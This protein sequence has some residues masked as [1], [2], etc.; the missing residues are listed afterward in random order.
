MPS[1]MYEIRTKGARGAMS[2]FAGLLSRYGLNSTRISRLVDS[3]LELL[4]EFGAR[5]TFP[6]TANVV[7]CHPD[8]FR[9]LMD[10]CELAV[11]GLTH[12]DYRALPRGTRRIHFETALRIFR[13]IGVERP[14]FRAPFLSADD[15]VLEDVR[16]AG[17]A[18]D[19]SASVMWPVVPETRA[20]SL[21]RAVYRS[22][23]TPAA[24][25]PSFN[26]GFARLVTSLPDDEMLV[27]RLHI[28]NPEV[29]ARIW[30]RAC[31]L[32]LALGAPFILEIHP[33]RFPY[34][35][36]ALRS[37]LV[38]LSTAEPAISILTLSET[39]ARARRGDSGRIVSV[40]GDIDVL[41]LLDLLS[42]PHPPVA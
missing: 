17:F 2:R 12:D 34:C 23:T 42:T 40:T 6:V 19:A 35:E 18:Y 25:M 33:E 38:D 11:H 20:L 4:E 36:E 15:T 32:C 29:L 37:L 30:R 39:A 5:P 28:R 22:Q 10:R 24:A 3:Y 26:D 7:A 16:H 41:G 1:I 13:T 21:A 8:L 27:D 31:G 9:G 14:G